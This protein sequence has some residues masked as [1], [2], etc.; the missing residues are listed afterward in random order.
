MSEGITH[1]GGQLWMEA[2]IEEAEALSL[3][4]D[5]TV[6]GWVCLGEVTEV[7]METSIEVET[8]WVGPDIEPLKGWEEL[9]ILAAAGLA[10]WGLLA[11]IGWGLWQAAKLL[12]G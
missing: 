12:F 10:A 4:E 6:T 8:G 7:E 5:D 9:A 11:A 1:E 3:E 2:P